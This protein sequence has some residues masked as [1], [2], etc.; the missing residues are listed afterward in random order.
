MKL[1]AL[2]HRL[3]YCTLRIP[4]DYLPNQYRLVVFDWLMPQIRIFSLPCIACHWPLAA[5]LIGTCCAFEHTLWWNLHSWYLAKYLLEMN[6]WRLKKPSRLSQQV[7]LACS[8]CLARSP[9]CWNPEP[10]QVWEW[11]RLS[12]L[13]ITADLS[14]EKTKS[15]MGTPPRLKK[16]VSPYMVCSCFVLLTLSLQW[17]SLNGTYC[18]TDF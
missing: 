13:P 6:N 8:V 18:S 16:W 5:P 17:F 1:A 4:K 10:P 2:D 9:G 3:C 12:V 14:F 15:R 7:W 11:A